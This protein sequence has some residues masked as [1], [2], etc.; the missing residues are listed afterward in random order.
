MIGMFIL[1]ASVPSNFQ[2]ATVLI[3]EY[4][5]ILLASP[6][7]PTLEKALDNACSQFI[8]SNTHDAA[9]RLFLLS[10]KSYSTEQLTGFL[11]R[12]RLR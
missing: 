4:A 2:I 7:P 12:H 8:S 11:L 5:T 9:N 6:S 3:L 10:Q 1:S